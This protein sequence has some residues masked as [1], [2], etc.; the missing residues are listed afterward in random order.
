MLVPRVSDLDQTAFFIDLNDLAREI[1][2]IIV[3]D[4][5]ICRIALS[6]EIVLTGGQYDSNQG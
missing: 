3:G 4:V 1:I 2:L 5:G 6:R